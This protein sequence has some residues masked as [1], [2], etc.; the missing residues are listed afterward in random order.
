MTKSYSNCI[1]LESQKNVT[2]SFLFSDIV[3]SSKL[4]KKYPEQ[5]NIN[6]MEHEK[7]MN[8][9]IQ[10]YNGIVI[11]TIGDAFMALFTSLEIAVYC[12]IEIQL[13]LIENPII[14]DSDYLQLRIGI[15]HGPA[16]ERNVLYQNTCLLKDYYGTSV[17]L[18][19]RMESKVSKKGFNIAFCCYKCKVPDTLINMLLNYKYP[20]KLEVYKDKCKKKER[21]RSMRLVS[22]NL[23]S[24]CYDVGLLKGVP[25]IDAFVIELSNIMV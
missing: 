6:L 10:K 1:N 16:K 18:A 25:P 7:R 17:N 11:K 9:F 21:R 5:M 15:C 2:N 22:P 20:L 8:H 23:E 14:F 19:S 24:V 4:W 3:G 12:A 13:D